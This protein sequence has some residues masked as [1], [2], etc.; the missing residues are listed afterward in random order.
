MLLEIKIILAYKITRLLLNVRYRRPDIDYGIVLSLGDQRLARRLVRLLIAD[1]LSQEGRW[2]RELE[3]EGR[4]DGRG[5][6]V[7]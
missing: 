3:G 6:L 2:E 1:P 7:R 4:D 5:I